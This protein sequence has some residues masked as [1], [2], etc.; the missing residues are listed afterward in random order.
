MPDDLIWDMPRTG[1]GT[2]LASDSILQASIGSQSRFE[3]NERRH[4]EFA[5]GHLTTDDQ[6]IGDFRDLL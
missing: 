1:I 3:S 6:C 5:A 4:V 2:Q